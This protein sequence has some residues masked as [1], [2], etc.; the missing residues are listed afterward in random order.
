MKKIYLSLV[1]LLAFSLFRNNLYGQANTPM[2]KC[3]GKYLGNVLDGTTN[4]G[5]DLKYSTYWNQAT[6]ENG[7]KWGSVQATTGSAYNFTTC[8]VAY[9]WAKNNGGFFKYHNL[10]WGSQPPSDVASA[11]T[12]TIQA[13]VQNYIAA[14]ASHY[15]SENIDLI[16]VFNEPVH[17]ALPG[18]YKAA[19][20]AGYQA[21]NPG[22]TDQYGWIIWV[23]QLARK[24]FPNAKLLLNEYSIENDPN[25]ALITYAAMANSVLNAPNLTDG[26]KNL[27]DGLGL[28]CHAFS[29]NGMAA[30][31]MQSAL[32]KLYGLTGLPMHIT[33]MDLDANP[34]ETTQ[35]T[36]YQALFPVMWGHPH[37]AGITLWGYVQGFTWRNG[38]GTAGPSG[39]DS[40]IMYA[41]TYTTNPGGERP[42]LTWIKN[43][44]ATQPDVTGCP[45]P[46][47]YGPGWA[48]QACTT[49][50]PTTTK[51]ITYCVGATA[52]QLTAT[53]GTGNTLNWYLTPAGAEGG[54]ALTAAPTP[55]T[56]AAGTTYY[57]VSQT[58]PGTSGCESFRDTI[59]VTVSSAASCSTATCSTAAPTVT[60]PI[61]YSQGATASPLT[62]TAGTGG[63]LNW[64]GTSATGGTAS[65]TAPT[66]STTTVGSTTY[67]VSQ[68]ISCEGPRAS[69]VVTVNAVTS[70]ITVSL[71]TP[72][73]NTTVASGSNVTL[74][75]TA[76]TTSGTISQVAF[77]QGSTL[78]GTATS[79]PYTV[80]WANPIA[81]TG[82]Y[83]L[84]AVATNSA[85]QTNTSSAVTVT[86]REPV[87]STTTAP[88][89]DGVAD[90]LWSNY[91]ANNIGHVIQG[92]VANS[93]YLSS[94]W[95]ATWD[96]TNLYMLVTVKDDVLVNT[97][98]AQAT[99]Y[100][101]DGIEIYLDMGNLKPTSYT[102]TNLFEYVFRW[103][104]A[105]VREL[106]HTATTGVK[107]AQ[108]SQGITAGCT[109]NCAAIGYTMEVAIP[110]TTL[111]LTAAPAVGALEGFDVAVNDDDTG[112]RNAKLSW[113]M[114]IDNDYRYPNDFGTVI[115]E[116]SPCTPPT[117]TISPSGTASF[118]TGSSTV[119]SANTGTGLTYQW[120]NGGTAI[121]GATAAT[122]TATAAGTYTVSVKNSGNCTATSAGTTVT[123]TALPAAPT[124]T[125]PVTYCQSAT[126]TALTATPSTGGTLNWYTVATGGTASSTAPTPST[127]AAGTTDYYVSQT[128]S[129]CEGPRATIAVTVNSLP[130][131][132]TVT[133]PVSYC[134][135][136]TA[137]ALTATGTAL[138][139]YTVSTGGTGST[140]APTPT[141][142][143]AGTTN[144]YVSQTTNSCEGPRATLAVTV[145]VTPA[146]PATSPVTYCQSASASALTA[147][148]STGGTLNW[149]TAATGG[150]ASSTAPTP[151]T[152]NAG[153]TNY[154]VSQT[155]SACEGPRATLA[156]T[157]NATPAAPATS[158]V[159][160]C[161]NAS[162][163]ALTATPSTGG[164]LNWYTAA[165][166]GTASSTAPTPST[167]NAGATNY[168]VSQTISTC[169][170]PRAT[171]AVTVNATPA[172]PT[173]SPVTYCQSAS[174]TALT[175]T[176]STGGTLNWYTAATG[177]TASST[178]PTP[179]TTSA[180]T[181]NYYVSQTVSAC[182]G[183]RAT[184]AVTVNATP[185]APAT[186]PLTYCQNTSAS[187]LTATGTSLKWY[188]SSTGGT[189]STTAPT[190]STT[191]AGT[192]D[193]YV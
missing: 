136:A 108:T 118:C 8:D 123:V 110:W 21:A 180:G 23:F 70:P 191:N 99:I 168:Y 9:N 97:N 13:A 183:P 142:T 75:A 192:T 18:N 69:I 120:Y 54:K 65:S 100:N 130:A 102:G 6:A 173:A 50:V 25:G 86:V 158:P 149:Y 56:A 87:Y 17:T 36:E 117:A 74:T 4:S 116:S 83:Q 92:T 115:M 3:K 126:A 184:L 63:T 125:S 129:T 144:Y 60:T 32:D 22:G 27:I 61:T 188:T 135:N 143:A 7:C 114:T 84:T 122:Y 10:A 172:A 2:G 26:R 177:G 169:E 11:S 164:T 111:G 131:A 148:P 153:T 93:T 1:I 134:Q 39:T 112:T 181:T 152:T 82:S 150:T 77:Y 41:S 38:N 139:W 137:S 103:N 49:A 96:A 73:N 57:Y 193:Y 66:P 167:T 165:T 154:Y 24:A 52:K 128:V 132:P 88:T 42:A 98:Q 58:S 44:M 72:T 162:A 40:G 62:A 119:L 156:V 101:D 104:D 20:T 190:P 53:A 64:Y 15:G 175:A 34:T 189:G 121:S 47:T 45:A 19:L 105:T 127:T 28:Q 71:T 107:F 160:Y 12:A 174:A 51:A 186:S 43:Y 182:E 176:P 55:S 187:A 106:Q 179:S 146:A 95:Q 159:T 79:S 94:T 16:D 140:T 68:T 85:S 90:G 163:S 46:G 29:I 178:A 14:V 109:T 5:A 81:D 171:L 133:S 124:A 67:Y 113:N 161:Q 185:A 48:T 138:K 33:E 31:T 89:I 80:T 30:S 59:I 145:N 37:V 170:G 155:I 35:S 78:I 91:P 166:G 76:S 141:T 157:V 151:S 147:T